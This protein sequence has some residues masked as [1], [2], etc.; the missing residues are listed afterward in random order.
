M[1]LSKKR[2][3]IT[4]PS[5][6]KKMSTTKNTAAA[7]A[8]ALP[9]AL[10]GCA[11]EEPAKEV[12]FQEDVQPILQANCVECHTAGG[13]GTAASGLVMTSY[14]GLMKGTR[15]GPVVEPGSSVSSTLV[16]LV[17]GKADPS[18]RMPHGRDPLPPEEIA[19]IKDWVDQG[20]KDN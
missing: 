13:Q 12:S 10:L 16:L 14:E 18:L 15:Y 17:E 7:A 9:L 6:M 2:A 8:V 1:M 19:V 20:A 11:G 3:Q 5:R 4:G